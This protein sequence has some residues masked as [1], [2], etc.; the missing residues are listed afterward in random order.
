MDTIMMVFPFID[1][2]IHKTYKHK[3]CICKLHNCISCNVCLRLCHDDVSMM[4]SKLIHHKNYM[5][6]FLRKKLYTAA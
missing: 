4:T 2:L 6:Q 3:A 1:T 5:F